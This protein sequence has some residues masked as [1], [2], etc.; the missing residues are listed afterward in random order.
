M[1]VNISFYCEIYFYKKYK[2]F[3]ENIKFIVEKWSTLNDIRTP[4]IN[5][6]H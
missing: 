4:D 1:Y 6:Y 5:Q 3:F 2:F